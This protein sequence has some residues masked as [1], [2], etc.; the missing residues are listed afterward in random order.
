MHLLF[1]INKHSRFWKPRSPKIWSPQAGVPGE[2]MGNS[3][4]K[5]SRLKTQAEPALQLGVRKQEK[6]NV[7][8]QDSP[9]GGAPPPLR[10][11]SISVAFA[12]LTD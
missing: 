5:A 7:P 8:T 12:P 3:D 2:L 1:V 4:A 6:P 10:Q 11:V 9:A